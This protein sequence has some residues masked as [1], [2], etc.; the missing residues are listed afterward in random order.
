MFATRTIVV[1]LVVGVVVTLL[2]ALRPALRATRVPP[3]AAVREGAVLPPSR[4]A[5]LRSA[6]ALAS[7]SAGAVALMLVGL[8]VGG[9]STGQRLLAI[10]I[11]AAGAVH[12]R[13]DAGPTLVPPLAAVLGWPATRIGGAAGRLA[14]GELDAQPAPDGLDRRPR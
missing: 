3:I 14:R 12:R 10:G 9:L 13:G 6:R 2:A 11:G 1:S 7:R 4:F 5:R 8:F